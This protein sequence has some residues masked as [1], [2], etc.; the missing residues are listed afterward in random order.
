MFNKDIT[1]PV[2][3]AARLG[4][5]LAELPLG[6]ALRLFRLNTTAHQGYNDSMPLT[7]GPSYTNASSP[8]VP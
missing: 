4:D 2:L 7:A 6:P 1:G 3:A 8:P 5:P